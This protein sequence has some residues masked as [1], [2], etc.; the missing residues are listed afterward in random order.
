MRSLKYLNL[1]VKPYSCGCETG[2]QSRDTD[3][4]LEFQDLSEQDQSL[5]N[6]ETLIIGGNLFKLYLL[7]YIYLTFFQ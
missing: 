7:L 6:L 2:I 1:T 3:V 4:D 5:S